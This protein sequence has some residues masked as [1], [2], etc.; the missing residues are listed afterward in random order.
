MKQNRKILSNKKGIELSINFIVMLVLAIAVFTGGLLFINKFFSEAEEIRMSIDAQTQRQIANLLDDGSPFVIPIR[1]QEVQ[2]G[3][4]VQFAVGVFNNG[5]AGE[6]FTLDVTFDAAY[7]LDNSFLCNAATTT[8]CNSNPQ[9]WIIPGS[10][11]TFT[12]KENEQVT[13]LFGFDV[14]QNAPRGNYIFFASLEDPWN[15]VPGYEPIQVV[16]Q[17]R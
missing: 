5:A 11:Q 10:S 3:E 9:D 2:N 13:R 7:K 16:L 8:G 6:E 15:D 17:V 14:P 12:V 1:T 4:F